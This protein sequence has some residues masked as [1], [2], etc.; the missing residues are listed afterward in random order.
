MSAGPRDDEKTLLKPNLSLTAA[1]GAGTLLRSGRGARAGAAI[2]H[3][4]SRDEDT[5][6]GP[7]HRFLESDLEVVPQV[8]AARDPPA[9][10]VAEEVRE[11]IF[12]DAAAS[13]DV[14]EL[15]ENVGIDLRTAKP[16]VAVSVVDR[17]L[18]VVAQDGVRLRRFLERLFRFRIVRILVRVILDRELAVGFLDFLRVRPAIDS[19]NVVV[20]AFRGACQTFS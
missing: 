16:L 10:S 20:V 19:E 9:P 6:L 14:G 11:E 12:E 18:V 1:R 8:R 3:L 7:P 2:A 15:A 5:G 17:A 4:R 13:E